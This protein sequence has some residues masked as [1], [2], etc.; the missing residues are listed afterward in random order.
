M[1]PMH[2]CGNVSLLKLPKTAFLCSRNISSS[3]VLK[4]YDWAIEQREKGQCVVG[5]FQSKIEKDVLHYLIQG[6][7]PLIIVLARGLKKRIE[8]ELKKELEKNRLLLLTPFDETVKRITSATAEK[9][10]RMM[11]EIADEIVFGYISKDGMLDRLKQE[12]KSKK[13]KIF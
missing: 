8:P 5:G 10:N 3:A 12:Y 7:Q 11:M 6:S 13:M 2:T 9:R 4:C 1:I